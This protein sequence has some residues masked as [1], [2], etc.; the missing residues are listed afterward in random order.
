[1]NETCLLKEIKIFSHLDNKSLEYIQ[2]YLYKKHYSKGESIFFEGDIVDK[3]L[4]LK[5]GKVELYKSNENGKKLTL[6]Y[7]ESKNPFCI[8][9]FVAGRAMSNAKAISNSIIYYINKNDADKIFSLYPA[10]YTEILSHM[11]DE[12]SIKLKILENIALSSA[13]ERVLNVIANQ[14]NIFTNENKCTISL[15]QEEIAA[16][17]GVC[18]ET[19]CRI[20]AKFKKE[21]ILNVQQKQ[22]IIKDIEKFKSLC[23]S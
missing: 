12:F 16:L 18:R 11:S 17:T 23:P 7:V 1:M 22:I 5:E 3:F 6:W 19:V 9:A 14:K 21:N 8:A 4:I 13:Q 10:I 20:L 2:K 15:S